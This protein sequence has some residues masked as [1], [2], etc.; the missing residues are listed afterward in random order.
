MAP[1]PSPALRKERRGGPGGWMVLV[2]VFAAFLCT[3]G[4]IPLGLV[5]FSN[6]ALGRLFPSFSAPTQGS[7]TPTPVRVVQAAP[8]PT[9][10]PTPIPTLKTP[11]LVG[12]SFTVARQLAQNAGLDVVISG[13]SY[14]SDYPVAYVISQNPVAGDPIE[15]GVRVEVVVSLGKESVQVPRVVEDPLQAAEDKLRAA[16][17][18]W[19]V[20]EQ[21]SDQTP[22]G[23]VISQNPAPDVAAENG[24]EVLLQVSLGKQKVA[25]PNLI[26]KPEA[27]AQDTIVKAGL[28]KSFPNYQGFTTVPPGDVISQEPKP[29]TMVDKGTT[30]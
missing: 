30:V 9:P 10:E 19:R 21:N 15:Q 25:V 6:G 8:S 28:A 26:G 23:I 24:S 17:F 20:M 7:A 14:S 2:V 4:S 29:G 5:A 11:K 16:G 27:E 13:E 12:M 22:A 18:K 1:V 3:L